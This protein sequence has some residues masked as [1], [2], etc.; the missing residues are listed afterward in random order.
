M[1]SRKPKL[2]SY[3]HLKMSIRHMNEAVA[4]R[5]RRQERLFHQALKKRA[6]R[7]I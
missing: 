5:Q 6:L 3:A 4:K 2:F 1:N 7:G